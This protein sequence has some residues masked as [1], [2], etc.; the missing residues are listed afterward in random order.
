MGKE[1][2]GSKNRERIS[3]KK[4]N[5][6]AWTHP[7]PRTG[8]TQWT[9]CSG[10]K[11]S[12]VDTITSTTGGERDSRK[13]APVRDPWKRQVTGTGLCRARGYLRTERFPTITARVKEII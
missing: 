6:A 9:Q 2:G 8:R 11:G 13:D 1:M 3:C 12:E 7:C 10:L 5:L 4:I